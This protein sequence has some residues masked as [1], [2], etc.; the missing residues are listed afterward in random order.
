LI[1]QTI[2]TLKRIDFNTILT[3]IQG[4][5]PFQDAALCHSF[6]A[7]QPGSDMAAEALLI[8]DYDYN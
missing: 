6:S 3:K 4:R 5:H 1:G 8:N 2:L 7:A